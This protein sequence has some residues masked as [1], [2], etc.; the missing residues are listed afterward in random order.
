VIPG[1]FR[2]GRLNQAAG[3][4]GG[5]GLSMGVE[6]SFCLEWDLIG[7]QQGNEFC[8]AARGSENRVLEFGAVG[9]VA[10][11]SGFRMRGHTLSASAGAHRRVEWECWLGSVNEVAPFS[12]SPADLLRSELLDQ[13]HRA[14]AV[15]T[16]PG[17]GQPGLPGGGCGEILTRAGLQQRLAQ[18]QQ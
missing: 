4:C 15:W 2:L 10:C 16:Q 5:R 7:Y 17:S 12:C 13:D 6:C 9:I 14:P 11:F 18:W 3:G 1:H 8:L